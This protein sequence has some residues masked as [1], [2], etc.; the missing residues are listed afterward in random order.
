MKK[1][2]EINR[3]AGPQRQIHGPTLNYLL[4]GGIT[5]S[6]GTIIPFLLQLDAI[7]HKVIKGDDMPSY[8]NYL[9]FG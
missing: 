7:H 1:V 8:L 9:T 4:I 6:I 5:T 2:L 3:K